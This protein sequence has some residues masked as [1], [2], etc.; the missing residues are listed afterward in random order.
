MTRFTKLIVLLLAAAHM[1][2]VSI[3]IMNHNR[4]SRQS[5]WKDWGFTSPIA[6]QS[7]LAQNFRS[8][9]GADLWL[10]P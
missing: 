6:T 5:C 3:I 10:E 4:R 1:L 9:A 7:A 2:R 8:R